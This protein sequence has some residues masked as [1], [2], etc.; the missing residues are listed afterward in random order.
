MDVQ[1][2][3]KVDQKV[4]AERGGW[5]A[6]NCNGCTCTND[7]V[8][9]VT[10]RREWRLDDKRVGTWSSEELATWCCGQS[11]AWYEWRLKEG[12]ADSA[13]TRHE[14]SEKPGARFGAL[15]LG[16]ALG[17]LIPS[18]LLLAYSICYHEPWADS[19]QTLLL[20]RHVPWSGFIHAMRLEG[21]PPLYHLLN[22]FLCLFM[23]PYVALALAGAIGYATLLA[24]TLQDELS[25][26]NAAGIVPD[27]ERRNRPARRRG[28]VHER[29]RR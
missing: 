12:V 11:G 18:V 5:E 21:A 3:E 19:A 23:P 4:E 25:N 14:K 27:D 8:W 20:G 22:W 2:W 7:S 29:R 16:S 15:R 17:V 10:C 1:K 26:R 24:G 6:S 28:H 9:R 13:M